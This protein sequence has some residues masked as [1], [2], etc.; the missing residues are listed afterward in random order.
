MGL[1]I[2][3]SLKTTNKVQDF[4][5]ENNYTLKGTPFEKFIDRND[6]MYW[7][8]GLNSI[9]DGRIDTNILDKQLFDRCDDISPN[10]KL[11]FRLIKFICAHTFSYLYM[12]KKCQF[13]KVEVR[14]HEPLY[15]SFILKQL[16]YDE[17]NKFSSSEN[18]KNADICARLVSILENFVSGYSLKDLIAEHGEKRKLT[19]ISSGKLFQKILTGM[20]EFLHKSDVKSF[21]NPKIQNNS[22]EIVLVVSEVMMKVNESALNPLTANVP[23]CKS[24][25]WFDNQL[26]MI[27]FFRFP[28]LD[29]LNRH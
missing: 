1:D 26:G 9:C 29:Y 28:D 4:F 13:K 27:D 8:I 6:N 17:V 12:G 11:C 16:L 2:A 14:Y 19:V 7:N 15:S 25:D 10:I 18:W 22:N 24:T 5:R 23:I 21:L 3:V 20:I